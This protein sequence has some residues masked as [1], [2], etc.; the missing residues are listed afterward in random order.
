MRSFATAQTVQE[1][2]ATPI[3]PAGDGQI[4]RLIGF[5]L[6]DFK[7]GDYTLVLRVADE[8]AGKSLELREPFA[9]LAEPN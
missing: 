3:E 6:A 7:P 8:V 5:G 4:Q 1:G 2:P 9:V